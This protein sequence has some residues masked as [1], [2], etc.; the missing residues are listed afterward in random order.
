[1]VELLMTEQD[2]LDRRLTVIRV[3]AGVALAALLVLAGLL[4]SGVRAA[5]KHHARGSLSVA[6]I[7]Q[8]P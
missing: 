6:A 2:E 5:E 4:L 3:S 7:T 1:M 8:Q